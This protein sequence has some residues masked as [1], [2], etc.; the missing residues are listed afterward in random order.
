MIELDKRLNKITDLINKCYETI[1][2]C[3]PKYPQFSFTRAM[4]IIWLNIVYKKMKPI[5]LERFV[6]TFKSLVEEKVKGS[7]NGK[8]YE[9]MDE[10]ASQKIEVL[11]Q[12][13]LLITLID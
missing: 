9:I 7:L 13:Y 8:S 1:C 10:K 3:F 5:L 12:Y 11:T 4:I 2:P 6:V